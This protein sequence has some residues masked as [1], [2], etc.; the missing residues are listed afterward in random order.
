[1]VLNIIVYWL[2]GRA[3][4]KSLIYI[5]YL[6]IGYFT[7]TI[8]QRVLIYPFID[9]VTEAQR[10]WYLSLDHTAGMEKLGFEPSI[11]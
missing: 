2:C 9:E 5:H 11:L 10:G 1:M 4:E 3:S 8:K 7:V 6:K